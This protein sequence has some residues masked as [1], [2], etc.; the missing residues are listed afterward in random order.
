MEGNLSKEA[1]IILGTTLDL[2]GLDPNIN[3]IDIYTI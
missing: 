1:F 2:K 3:G